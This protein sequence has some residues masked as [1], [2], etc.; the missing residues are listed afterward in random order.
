MVR[1]VYTIVKIIF[2][3]TLPFILLIRGAVYVHHEYNPGAYLSLAGGGLLAVIV[4][5][6]YLSFVSGYISKKLRV[7]RSFRRKGAIA[8]LIVAGY[9]IHGLFFLSSKNIKSPELKK[10]ITD[11]H[12]VLRVAVST[13]IFIDKDLIITDASRTP[14]DYK[15]MGL[16]SKRNSLHFKQ[17]NGYVHAFDIRVKNRSWLRNGLLQLYFKAMGFNTLRH[18]GTG[19]HLHISLTSRDRP[20]AIY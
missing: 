16:K 19:D 14:E 6:V 10:E 11:L 15:R 12:P 8:L 17:S 9:S 4:I 20:W 7:M 5:I 3:L 1:I 2:I 18:G 13:I